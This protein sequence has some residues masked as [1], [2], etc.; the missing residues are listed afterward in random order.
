MK[1]SNIKIGVSLL[2]LVMSSTSMS[3]AQ[4]SSD[5]AEAGR[6]DEIIVTARRKAESLQSTPVTV[7]AYNAR[8]IETR[9]IT[10]TSELANFTPN[11]TFDTTSTFSGAAS[12]FQGFI[13]GIGQSDFAINTD[14][15]VGVYIDDV[16]IARTVGS[17][18]SLYD[19][20]QVEIL[21]GPQGTLFGR[22]TIGG[23]VN[24]QTKRP[25]ENFAFKGSVEYGRFDRIAV[26]AAVN[27]P[28]AEGLNASIAVST[29]QQDG[30]QERI[31]PDI[32]NI[33][34]VI[35]PGNLAGTPQGDT[36]GA[37]DNQALRAKVLWE[38]NDRLETTF[39][40]D[41]SRARDS[42]PAQSVVALIGSQEATGINAAAAANPFDPATGE[43]NL[44]V[45]Q[46]GGLNPDS[47]AFAFNGCLLGLAPPPLCAT[48]GELG[49]NITG[50]NADADTSNDLPL[51]GAGVISDDIDQTFATGTNFSTFDSYGFSNVT[52]F[53][54][55][56]N[57]ELKTI[58]AYRE[59]DA[60]FGTDLDGSPLAVNNLIFSID[61]S[62]FSGE[63]QLNGSLLEDRL[64]F[65]VGG[66]YFD[67]EAV[68]SDQVLIGSVLQIG[69][70]NSQDTEAFALFGEANYKITP[71]LTALFGIRYTDE[72]KSLRIDQQSL[73]N[74]FGVVLAAPFPS[75][76]LED[77]DGD[78]VFPRTNAD[79]TP[80]VN[81]LGPDGPQVA[82]FDDVS[83]RLGLN[84]QVT[85]DVFGYATFSQGFKSGGFTTRLTAPF[86]PN[87]NPDAALIGG[88]V[89]PGLSSLVF[90]PE[91]SNNYEIGVKADL[92]GGNVRANAAAFWNEYQDIQIVVTRGISPANENAGDGR[93]RGIELELEAYPTDQL[94]LVGSFGYTDAEYTD[95]DPLAA[96]VTEDSAFQNTPEFSFAL[97]GNYVVPV[98]SGN[99]T[100]NANYSWKSEIAN[101]AQNT[102]ELIQD[103]VGLLGG[104]VKYEP[105]DG[106]W[107]LSFI[108]RNITDERFIGGGFNAGTGASLVSAT[109]NRPAEWRVKLDVDF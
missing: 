53:D 73:T 69:G 109:F 107:A 54:V 29:E 6:L 13:R 71:D 90:E 25:D 102:P 84:Y 46:A 19:I 70:D 66:F 39:S 99:V 15:G 3:Y 31:F 43:G 91:T 83:I 14:P 58:L 80:N 34:N 92:F 8:A 55:T 30:Y 21:K 61:Q 105:E 76:F 74:F 16:Y 82:S 37:L 86:N 41:F 11:A 104:H 65:T 78:S 68:Q 64:D 95:V 51:F 103:S 9:G 22:N 36:L 24:I 106:N 23:A 38:V 63:I 26:D 75:G 44:S 93:I 62:Q 56:D 5:Q 27:V 57:L 40:G 52:S 59:L 77:G 89:P 33:N 81:F 10:D 12:T 1:N 85:D 98:A 48:T 97:A 96:P 67:E 47:L 87:F 72:E 101:D 20:E 18:F 49:R 4:T 88:G 60:R 108:G 45:A 100:L 17:V 2:A 28:L 32:P 79:G 35:A 94:S 50:L 42:A 7:S